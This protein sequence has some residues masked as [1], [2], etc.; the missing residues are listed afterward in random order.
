MA[1]RPRIERMGEV[2]QQLPEDLE[3]MA[4]GPELATLLASLDRTALSGA[5]RV[6]LLRARHRLV[7]HLQGEMYADMYAI[8]RDEPAQDPDVLAHEE[9][10]EPYPWASTEISF[11]LRWTY[12][13]ASVRLEHA[14]RMIEDLPAVAAAL[15]AGAIDVPKALLLC[16]EV[17]MLEL[18][19]ARRIIDR[20]IDKAADMT[21]G[22]LRAKLRRLVIAADPAAAANRAKVGVAGR[23]VV[24]AQ[25]HQNLASISGYDALPHRV[26]ASYERLTAIARAAKSAG[27]PRR[28]DELRLDAMLDLLSGEGVATGGPITNGGFE[29]LPAID[30]AACQP[31]ANTPWPT[32]PADPDLLTAA[33]DPVAPSQADEAGVTQPLDP[34]DQP[35]AEVDGDPTI[36]PEHERLRPYWLA[37][38]DQLPTSHP[39]ACSHCGRDAGQRGPMPAPRRGA[40]DLQMSLTTLMGL[41]DLPAELSGF[42]PLLADI[43]RQV[44]EQRPDLQLR[45]SAY[46]EIDSLLVHG[47]TKI[48]P[49][50]RP[51]GRRTKRRPT[52]EVAALVRARNRTCAAPGCRVPSLRCE[53]D[54]V[55]AWASNGESEPDNLDPSCPRHHRFKHAPGSDL[56]AFNPG[57]FGWQTPLGMQY[58]SKPDPPLY[59][60]HRYIHPPMPGD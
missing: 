58:M 20:L 24:I 36:D 43:A 6:R 32:A 34:P 39:A 19:I 44:V 51:P 18:P 42:G 27:D 4:P 17:C 7:A 53:L 5:E 31:D 21:T 55:L 14:R 8:S 25:D 56:V 2:R 9:P 54:H 22:Q 60:D 46:N 23:R 45:F 41:D 10:S 52:A 28:M 12:T 29:E 1:R 3:N 16:D 35:P 47:T 15:R 37:G 13:A 57:S 26:A 40:I 30:E 38:F 11:A 59:D 50:F 48:R 33:A 49:R